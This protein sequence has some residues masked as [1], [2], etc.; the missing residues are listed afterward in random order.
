MKHWAL[1]LLLQVY[2][3]PW[4]TSR[5]NES[6]YCGW[7]WIHFCW[8]VVIYN[9]RNLT[10]SVNPCI[11]LQQFKKTQVWV[12]C[13]VKYPC[14]YVLLTW[15]T[16]VGM[17]IWISYHVL[18]S[19]SNNI[20]KNQS[21]WIQIS[22]ADLVHSS[23]AGTCTNTTASSCDVSGWLFLFPHLR[24]TMMTGKMAQWLR[25][26]HVLLLHTIWVQVPALILGRWQPSA[27]PAPTH[28]CIYLHRNTYTHT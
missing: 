14:S 12:S 8:N 23:S 10:T 7:A 17:M 26:Q 2:D 27:I 3:E 25:E 5:T 19:K 11:M 18:L 20:T 15:G 28:L 16:K 1:W 21:F 24:T 9:L 13:V 4:Y 22:V 6:I